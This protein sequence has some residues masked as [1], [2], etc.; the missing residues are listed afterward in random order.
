M[1]TELVEKAL[2]S[3]LGQRSPATDML[4]HSDQGSQYASASYSS[5]LG[6]RGITMSMSRRGDCYDNAVVES[7]F[8][9]LKQELVHHARWEDL[10][11]ARAALHDY[12][13][14]FYN[15]QRLHSSVGY[16]TPAEADQ[17]AA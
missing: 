9:S 15:R 5:M 6:A 4:H 8:G 16:R 1:R 2:E 11:E 10:A 13:E 3:A 12:I 7:F 17:E 14:V